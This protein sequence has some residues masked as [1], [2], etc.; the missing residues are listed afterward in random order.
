MLPSFFFPLSRRW[1]GVLELSISLPPVGQATV[2]QLPQRRALI[3]TEHSAVFKNNV[4]PP[5][6]PGVQ[7]GF[8][9][10][11]LVTTGGKSPENLKT[12]GSLLEFLPL[13]FAHNEPPPINNYK[14]GFLALGLVPKMVS[15]PGLLSGKLWFPATVVCLSRQLPVSQVCPLS[16]IF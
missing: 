10:E 9:Y 4:F 2:N 12:S 7:R 8:H 15:A 11:S 1:L 13:E 5:P 14:L 6:L 16:S 3:G